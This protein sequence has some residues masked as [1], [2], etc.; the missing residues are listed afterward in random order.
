MMIEVNEQ[1]ELQSKQSLL[2]LADDVI[3]LERVYQNEIKRL[4][5]Q[6]AA[7]LAAGNE[8]AD[9]LK[10][11]CSPEEW[12]VKMRAALAAWSEITKND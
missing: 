6:N 1:G 3:E 9:V 7:L 4:M 2:D 12:D 10:D 5:E 8:M 11:V